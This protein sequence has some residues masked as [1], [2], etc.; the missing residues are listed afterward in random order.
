MTDDFGDIEG[1]HAMSDS[2]E[3]DDRCDKLI[4]RSAKPLEQ[5]I[6]QLRM[7]LLALFTFRHLNHAPL[8]ARV[9][10]PA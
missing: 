10:V 2:E 3:E 7:R 4:E 1:E 5:G 6:F 8:R 9:G